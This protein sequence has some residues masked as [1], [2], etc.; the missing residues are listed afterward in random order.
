[1][2]APQPQPVILL[3]HRIGRPELDPWG[4]SVSPE[5]FVQQMAYLRQFRRPMALDGFVDGL[6]Q[7]QLPANAVA[8]TFDDGYVDNLTVAKPIL[9]ATWSRR[10]SSLS[11]G[12]PLRRPGSGGTKWP[13]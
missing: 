11:R 9:A 1:M 6:C 12:Q 2:A 13:D 10:H 3:Y 5:N 7:G 8:V 4:L